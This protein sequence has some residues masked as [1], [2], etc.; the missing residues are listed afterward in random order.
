[1]KKR[2]NVALVAIR[3]GDSAALVAAV[4]Y[5]DVAMVQLAA[6]ARNEVF[7]LDT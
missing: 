2:G 1:M 7:V 4:T 3:V 5:F 6:D